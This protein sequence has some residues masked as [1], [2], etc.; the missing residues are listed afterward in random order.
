MNFVVVV[1]FIF[2]SCCCLVLGF[3][4]ASLFVFVDYGQVLCSLM[5]GRHLRPSFVFP[6]GQ[7]LGNK[8]TEL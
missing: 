5:D 8:V 2:Q 4:G 1:F 7:F 3:K 6:L